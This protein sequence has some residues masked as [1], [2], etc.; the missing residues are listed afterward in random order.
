VDWGA[1]AADIAFA[2]QQRPGRI[3]LHGFDMLKNL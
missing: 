3:Y 2:L 1:N